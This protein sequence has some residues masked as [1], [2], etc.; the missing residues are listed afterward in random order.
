[1]IDNAID[2]S[3]VTFLKHVDRSQLFKI[4]QTLGYEH[5]PEKGLYMSNDYHVSYH[6]SV[7]HGDRVY[8]F[9]HSAIE[10]VFTR[11]K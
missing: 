1:M 7:L 9:K 10:H 5:W 6:R 3:R 8:F 11:S 2:I 4:E